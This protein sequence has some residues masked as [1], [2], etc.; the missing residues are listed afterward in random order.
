MS[1]AIRMRMDERER[2]G[3]WIQAADVT[4]ALFCIMVSMAGMGKIFQNGELIGFH[5]GA[6]RPLERDGSHSM[7]QLK[8]TLRQLQQENQEKEE[9]LKRQKQALARLEDQ[10]RATRAETPQGEGDG[11]G[12]RSE[13][14]REKGELAED[15]LRLQGINSRVSEKRLEVD[16]LERGLPLLQERVTASQQR[17]QALRDQQHD[18]ADLQAKLAARRGELAKLQAP[19]P[20][21]GQKVI[22]VSS[23]PLVA[24]RTDKK[25]ALMI[26]LVEGRVVPVKEP[27]YAFEAVPP[28]ENNGRYERAIKGRRVQQGE[29]LE[30]A[31]AQTSLFSRSLDD[32]NPQGEYV[33]LLVHSDSFATFRTVREMLKKRGIGY[34]WEPGKGDTVVFSSRGTEVLPFVE[35]EER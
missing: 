34:G 28:I 23:T 32:V 4:T 7:D 33:I 26:E 5:E 29:S 1:V 35:G 22:P 21:A 15:E 16:L 24:S 25:A 14:G 18:F 30:Q 20:A 12:D 2:A 27:F 19:S 11:A 8:E 3:F 9:E 13:T 10:Y 31:Q 6:S 17:E